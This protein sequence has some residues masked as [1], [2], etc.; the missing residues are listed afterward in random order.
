MWS[1]VLQRWSKLKLELP[2]LLAQPV[3]A[4]R[5]GESMRVDSTKL[6]APVLTSRALQNMRRKKRLSC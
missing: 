5:S 3:A 6:S 4:K 1:L 2:A